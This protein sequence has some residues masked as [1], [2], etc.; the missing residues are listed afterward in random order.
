MVFVVGAVLIAP[1]YIDW[2][3][4]RGQIEAYGERLTGRDVSIDGDIGFIL[5]PAPALTISDFS[6]AN[7]E[8]A[9]ETPRNAGGVAAAANGRH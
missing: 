9:S 8:D 4:Y 3:Q 1:S 5:L 2:N 7:S 6:V